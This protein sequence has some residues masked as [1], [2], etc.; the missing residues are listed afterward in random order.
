MYGV[1]NIRITYMHLCYRG[2]MKHT[3]R[4]LADTADCLSNGDMVE[5]KIRSSSQWSLLPI[6]V[7]LWRELLCVI[8]CIPII[9]YTHYR[10]MRIH[11]NMY[12]YVLFC[13]HACTHAQKSVYVIMCTQTCTRIQICTYIHVHVHTHP[14]MHTCTH[15]V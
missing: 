10:H 7:S 2:D 15:I 4:L 11:I 3:L 9:M 12:I 14:R 1:L 13:M 8:L 5:K 6:Q